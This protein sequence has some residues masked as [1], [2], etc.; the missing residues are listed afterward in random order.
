MVQSI[1]EICNKPNSD[2]QW[3]VEQEDGSNVIFSFTEE[4]WEW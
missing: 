2:Y 1:T 3:G 4:D